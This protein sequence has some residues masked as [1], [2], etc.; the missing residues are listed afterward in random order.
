MTKTLVLLLLVASS[1]LMAQDNHYWTHQ[2]GTRSALMGGQVLGSVN[3]SSATFYNP[4]RLGFIE[5]E[6][7][8]ISADGYQIAGFNIVNGAG[9][10]LSLD[11]NQ[12]DIVSLASGGV[13][14][15]DGLPG[16]AFSYQ[17][18][19]RQ[20]FDANVSVRKQETLNV[21]DD[22]R[23]A[24]N[25]TYIGTF[26]FNSDIEEYW[27][28]IGWG[29]AINQH[30]GVGVT[31]FGILRFDEFGNDLTTRAVS[32]D[33]TVRGTEFSVGSDYWNVRTLLKFGFSGS[34]NGWNFG[35]TVTTASASLGGSATAR[36]QTTIFGIDNDGDGVESNFEANAH[37]DGL[38]SEY[39][40]PWSFALGIDW[41]FENWVLATAWEGFLPVGKYTVIEARDEP[42]LQGVPVADTAKDFLTVVDGKR[43]V[44]NFGLAADVQLNEDWH[45]MWSL[46]LDAAG[47]YLHDEGNSIALG[48]S[49]WNLV[50]FTVGF[51]W[52]TLM[53]DGRK[54]HEVTAGLQITGGNDTIDQPVNFDNPTEARL[55]LS[56]T[57]TAEL[58][59]AGI[60]IFLGYTYFF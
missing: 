10:D 29:W 27:A 20:F 49:T 25:E 18:L 28:G 8:R 11:S 13:F 31:H 41:H 48:I 6:H 55:L 35:F 51:T 40:S 19:T 59:Y 37:Q 7:L 56:P 17:V 30:F 32:G 60:A 57:S 44:L 58:S 50:H 54:K 22:L 34:F 46:R 9:E 23:S 24:G 43:G 15:F 39:R 33:G 42:Y 16:H 14:L 52:M 12:F 21:I 3:D 26:S 5:N 47:D 45:L 38:G 36:R 4:G 1:A 2:A 53:E